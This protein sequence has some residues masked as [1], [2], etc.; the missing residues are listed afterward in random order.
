MQYCSLKHWTLLPSPVTSITG[1][2]F[3]FG[4]IPSFFLELF[5]HWS[6]V[7]FWATTCPILCYLL[8]C[9]LPSSSLHG[10]FKAKGPERVAI[11]FSRGIFP[12]QGSYPCLLLQQ[13]SSYLM[14]SASVDLQVQEETEGGK[15]GLRGKKTDNTKP[16][17]PSLYPKKSNV[18]DIAI[19]LHYLLNIFASISNVYWNW[20]FHYHCLHYFINYC[21]FKLLNFKLVNPVTL[22]LAFPFLF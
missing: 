2:C 19:G 21:M 10:I 3:F 15:R 4:S 18:F 13:A 7:A 11:S 12:D 8:D 14:T 9:S 5:L 6:P 1:C 22:S 16:T 17:Y 20:L